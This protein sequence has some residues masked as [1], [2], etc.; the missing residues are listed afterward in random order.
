MDRRVFLRAVAGG[1][2]AAPLAAEAQ[3]AG[4]VWRIGL[5]VPGLPPGCGRDA[6]P[7]ALLALRDGFREHGYVESQDYILVIRC[8][9]REGP[10][11]QQAAEEIVRD[12]VDAVI[13]ASNE[14]ARAMSKATATVPVV[15]FAVNDPEEEG[16]VA[17]VARPG[18]NITGLSH[19]TGELAGKRL[20]LL[21]DALP[22]LQRLAV[23]A[24]Q[25]NRPAEHECLRLGL[26]VQL[27]A[28]PEPGDIGPAFTA[29]RRAR[30]EGLLVLPHPM[31]WLERRRIVTLASE[32]GVPAI[33]ENKDFVTSG[34]LMAYGA[35]LVDMS[36]RVTD[37][38]DR[39]L[40]GTKPAD[41][42]I[43]RPTKFELVIN[44][45]TAKALGLTI[46]QSLL[47]RADQVID[48]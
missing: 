9:V 38:V 39:I 12:K 16:L 18:G 23:L 43:E 22:K 15:F 42:P 30:P 19:M 1:L 35:S 26:D 40:K 48:P 17:S 14:L 2:L 47:L 25:K 44:L 11:M 21:K 3:Q 27:F 45:K 24:T 6:P 34:G 13:V 37:Y 31:F 5:L 8:A 4:K 36:R 46:P 32:I 33:Y 28:A 41:L 10:E 7:P 29:M 20:Q